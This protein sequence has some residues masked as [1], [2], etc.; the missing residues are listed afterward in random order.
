MDLLSIFHALCWTVSMGLF[1]LGPVIGWL[2]KGGTKI[3][4]QEENAYSLPWCCGLA[5]FFYQ[6]LY[7]LSGGYHHVTCCLPGLSPCPRPRVVRS[8]SAVSSPSA[9]APLLFSLKSVHPVTLS[10]WA[11]G[12]VP[13]CLCQSLTDYD[14]QHSNSLFRNHVCAC[15]LKLQTQTLF[16]SHLSCLLHEQMKFPTG[17]SRA[18]SDED[19]QS[20]PV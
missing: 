16:Q 8:D 13:S 1:G 10:S 18:T 7:L 20:P 2:P 17:W 6:I 9:T 4:G 14:T 19:L 5:V 12:T 15:L 11:S 3:R